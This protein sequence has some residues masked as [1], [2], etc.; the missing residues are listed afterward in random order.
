M[1]K[2]IYHEHNVRPSKLKLC[3]T[4]I[5]IVNHII[6]FVDINAYVIVGYQSSC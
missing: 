4:I 2:N 6:I 3:D 1:Y 5:Y